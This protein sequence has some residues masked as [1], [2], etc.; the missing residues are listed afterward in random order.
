MEIMLIYNSV[1]NVITAV[2]VVPQPTRAQR[3]GLD[4]TPGFQEVHAPGILRQLA[5]EGGTFV[6]A[7]RQHTPPSPPPPKGDPW[8]AFMLETES[9][10][11]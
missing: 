10:P 6:N 5:H 3:T 8:Y 11:V 1:R 9:S 2:Q 4:R 7:T